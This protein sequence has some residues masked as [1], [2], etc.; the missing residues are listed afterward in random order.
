MKTKIK[1]A[2]VLTAL[3]LSTTLSLK[4]AAAQQAYV[5]FQVFY[6]QLSPYG[7]WVDYPNYGYVWI[8]NVG[9]DFTPYYTNGHWIY[10][11]YGWTWVSNYPWGWATFHYGR[12]GYDDTYG[13]FWVPDETWGP[14]WVVW[15]SSGDY[16]GWGPMEPGISVSV[17]FGLPYIRQ[18]RHWIFIRNRYI[19][20]PDLYKYRFRPAN[21]NTFIDRAIIINNRR[22]DSQRHAT[23]MSGP[24]RDQAQRYTGRRITTYTIENNDRPVRK[25]D[26]GRLRIYR[27][28]VRKSVD[29][30][31]RP[32]PSKVYKLK[33]VK[34]PAERGTKKKSDGKRKR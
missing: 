15:V 23:Y 29:Q 17:S 24:A 9:S 8:P 7:Q 34:R 19:D 32:V 26:N 33:D 4:Q 27:P 20:R 22:V 30:G 1:I 14:A 6:D 12:W 13:W 5:S 11:D 10:T 21:R 31:R 3:I 28:E 16:Y 25:L 2:A 18:Y